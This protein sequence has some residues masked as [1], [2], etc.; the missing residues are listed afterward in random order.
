VD[1]QQLLPRATPQEVGE[2]VAELVAVLGRD[3][4]Y[5]VAPAHEI[6][7]DV[8]AENILAWVETLKRL[9]GAD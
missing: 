4:G 1:V 7:D 6:Q 2:A 5:V 3:G 8:P 9:S